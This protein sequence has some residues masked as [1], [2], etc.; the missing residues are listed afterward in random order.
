MGGCAVVVACQKTPPAATTQSTNTPAQNKPK[1]HIH[2]TQTRDAIEA[3][4]HEAL[5]AS[6]RDAPAAARAPG[7]GADDGELAEFY[8]ADDDEDGGGGGAGSGADD[9]AGA[10]DD[11][12]ARIERQ[13]QLAGKK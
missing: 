4:V 12:E 7:A 9:D 5:T 10:L 2:L 8:G 6:R 13:A 1:H 3:G 11:L